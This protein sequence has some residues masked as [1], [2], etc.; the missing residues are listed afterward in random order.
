MADLRSGTKYDVFRN[1]DSKVR[2]YGD[3]AVVTGITRVEGKADGKP[4][5]LDFQFTDTYVRKGG[6]WVI[7]ASQAARLAKE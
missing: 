4:Y 1:R 3:A 2:L 6:E 7:V 5:S